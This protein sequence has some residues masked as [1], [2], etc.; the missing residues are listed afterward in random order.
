M[1]TNPQEVLKAAGWMTL[2]SSPI[3]LALDCCKVTGIKIYCDDKP[4]GTNK[5]KKTPAANNGRKLFQERGQEKPVYVLP[6]VQYI[7][8]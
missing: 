3:K 1:P 2:F 7:Y 4:T 8:D 6:R 5:L